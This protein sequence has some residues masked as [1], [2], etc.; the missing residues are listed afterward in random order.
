MKYMDMVTSPKRRATGMNALMCFISA[1]TGIIVGFCLILVFYIVTEPNPN[2]IPQHFNDVEH[3]IKTFD[4][5]KNE[6]TRLK[7]AQIQSLH[8]R[9]IYILLQEVKTLKDK[10]KD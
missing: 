9:S 8:G 5:L 2:E 1:A 6:N 3:A 7:T 10:Q 4:V